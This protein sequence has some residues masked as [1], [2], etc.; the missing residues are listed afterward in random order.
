ML[1]RCAWSSPGEAEHAAGVKL[2]VL[3]VDTFK[4]AFFTWPIAVSVMFSFL[5]RL[6]VEAVTVLSGSNR[7]CFFQ[8]CNGLVIISTFRFCFPNKNLFQS[9]ITN[10][11]C[12]IL[13]QKRFYFD[14]KF[15]FSSSSFNAKF[16]SSNL[17]MLDKSRRWFRFENE[18]A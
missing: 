1:G 9:C 12:R 10:Y 17:G 15:H 7:D 2:A 18:V 5:L 14:P 13:I 8:G 16:T 4:P 11:L 3:S 6:L